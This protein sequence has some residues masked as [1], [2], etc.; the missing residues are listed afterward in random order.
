MILIMA[1]R[2]K[3]SFFI[4]FVL[5]ASGGVVGCAATVRLVSWWYSS[6]G[7]IA[8][9]GAT[10]SHSPS[11]SSTAARTTSLWPQ[12]LKSGTAARARH[13]F[14]VAFGKDRVM[15][16]IIIHPLNLASSCTDATASFFFLFF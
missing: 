8:D 3:F 12:P 10:A 9:G 6:A 11:S 1:V 7:D 2:G 13:L 14:P 5:F 15:H 16:T 4:D